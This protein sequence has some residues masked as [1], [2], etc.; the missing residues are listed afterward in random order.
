MILHNNFTISK[1]KDELFVNGHHIKFNIY[2]FFPRCGILSD[3]IYSGELNISLNFSKQ[4]DGLKYVIPWKSASI[5]SA[6]WLSI[7]QIY[8]FNIIISSYH[9]QTRGRLRVLL[10]ADRRTSSNGS[11]KSAAPTNAFTLNS[12][13]P[14]PCNAVLILG[15]Q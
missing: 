7:A 2:T 3:I 8:Y 14:A 12:G 6:V 10:I 15:L 4:L 5:T 13:L 1:I 9:C 11:W